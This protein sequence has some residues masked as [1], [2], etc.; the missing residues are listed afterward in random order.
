MYHPV[1]TPQHAFAPLSLARFTE[2]VLVPHIA[3]RLIA[4]DLSC[5]LEDAYEEMLDSIL[6]GQSL[7]PERD[8]DDELEY[9]LDM[10][11]RASKS[12]GKENEDNMGTRQCRTRRK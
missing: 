11:A 12:D 3:C 6:T 1:K 10:N 5:S 9:I 7:Q 8:H 2:C 4:E